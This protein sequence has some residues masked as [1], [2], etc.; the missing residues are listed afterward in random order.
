MFA[1]LDQGKNVDQVVHVMATHHAA[2]AH[3]KIQPLWKGNRFGRCMSKKLG[4]ADVKAVIKAFSEPQVRAALK[5]RQW[6]KASSIA[7]NILKRMSPRLAKEL[8]KRATHYV[9]P[10]GAVGALAFALTQCSLG[11]LELW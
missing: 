3:G 10:G 4:I 7:F 1:L 11:E 6:K 9:L 5:S 2:S 8:I